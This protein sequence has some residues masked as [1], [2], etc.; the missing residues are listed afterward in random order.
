MKQAKAQAARNLFDKMAGKIPP[1]YDNEVKPPVVR[2][3]FRNS[4]CI[5]HNYCV[6]RDLSTP[7]YTTPLAP[8]PGRRLTICRC[9]PFEA[10]G[11]GPS[12]KVARGNAARGIISQLE[13]RYGVP[14]P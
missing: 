6:Q 8:G 13:A 5:L 10:S 9:G 2:A 11:A 1:W 3:C 14:I 12:R 7:R 4:V